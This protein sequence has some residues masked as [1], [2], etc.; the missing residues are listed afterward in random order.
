[1]PSIDPTVRLL[2][3]LRQESLE[4]RR[5]LPPEAK[6][7]PGAGA[8]KA[9]PR[10]DAMGVAVRQAAAIDPQDPEARSKAFRLYL[11]ALFRNEFGARAAEDPGFPGL[12][13]RVR[14]TMQAD[15]ELRQAI[16]R[17]GEWLLKTARGG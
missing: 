15:P 7:L 16:D 5:R 3:H 9:A 17:A 1:M 6:A 13:D 4:W 10:Q 11:A 14:D 12:V 2:A 8:Q